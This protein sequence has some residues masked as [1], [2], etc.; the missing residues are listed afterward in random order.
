MKTFYLITL[1]VVI[2]MKILALGAA[3]WSLFHHHIE[4]AM[5]AALTAMWM[6]SLEISART[7]LEIS[8]K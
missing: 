5:W 6:L 8:R 3:M 4:D 2:A 7:R 1:I